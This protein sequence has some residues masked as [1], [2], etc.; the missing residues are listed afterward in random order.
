MEEYEVLPSDIFLEFLS[1]RFP[2]HKSLHLC[3]FFSSLNM[4][5]E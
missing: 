4:S 3:Q 1:F 2:P 5:T